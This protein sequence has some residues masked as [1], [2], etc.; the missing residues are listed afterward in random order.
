MAHIM[1]SVTIQTLHTG[2][3]V[4]IHWF[5][6]FLYF[7]NKRVALVSD[8]FFGVDEFGSNM[9]NLCFTVNDLSLLMEV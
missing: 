6:F 4:I 1:T 3:Q 8:L 7:K 9:D 5:S 2:F